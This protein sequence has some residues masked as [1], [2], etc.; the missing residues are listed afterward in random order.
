MHA[1][2]RH[3]SVVTKRSYGN[4]VQWHDGGIVAQA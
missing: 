3:V 1:R 4:E 2:V